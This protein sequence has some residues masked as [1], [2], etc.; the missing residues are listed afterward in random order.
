MKNVFLFFRNSFQKICCNF[1]GELIQKG[2]FDV[3]TN[4]IIKGTHRED[5]CLKP[6]TLCAIMTLCTRP[7]IDGNFSKN[8]MSLFLST[9]ISVPALIYNLKSHAPNCIQT[10]QSLNILEKILHI[11]HDYSWFKEFS[12]SVAGTKTLALL[13]NLVHLFCLEPTSSY[14]EMIVSISYNAVLC[15]FFNKYTLRP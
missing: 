14:P 2:F 12:S 7:I 13:A 1:Q 8:I 4:I 10:L 5:L 9:V 15:F 11:S 3:M 6:V